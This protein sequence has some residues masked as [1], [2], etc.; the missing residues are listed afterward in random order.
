M[1][2]EKCLLSQL[3]GLIWKIER[4]EVEEEEE[5]EELRACRFKATTDL[6]K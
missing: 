1:D 6:I 2:K 5:D 4:R 3:S